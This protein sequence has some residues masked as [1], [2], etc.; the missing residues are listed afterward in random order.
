MIHV[1]GCESAS[2]NTQRK[3]AVYLLYL[4]SVP[5]L[6]SFQGHTHQS[7]MI[8]SGH[9]VLP[10][11]VA[12]PVA[13]G[14]LG[15]AIGVAHF[16]AFLLS[17]DVDHRRLADGECQRSD[18]QRHRMSLAACVHVGKGRR[19]RRGT[20]PDAE[21]VGAKC[22]APS[23]IDTPNSPQRVRISSFTCPVM[24]GWRAPLP[25]GVWE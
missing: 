14:R 16:D 8:V 2:T 5:M 23:R 21:V 9:D 11:V 22:S 3:S 25:S 19:A 10:V 13:E 18:G 17:K 4:M 1:R 12:E 24:P 15:A 7:Y 6:A 20:P